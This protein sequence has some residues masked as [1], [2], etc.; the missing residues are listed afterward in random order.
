VRRIR[1]MTLGALSEGGLMRITEPFMNV[2]FVG[3]ETADVWRDYMEGGVRSEERGAK[4]IIEAL[5]SCRTL[6]ANLG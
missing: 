2:H 4:E 1:S 3:T 6:W 5:G